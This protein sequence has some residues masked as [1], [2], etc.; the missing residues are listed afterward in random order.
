MGDG[1]AG[2]LPYLQ[3]SPLGLVVV[4]LLRLWTRAVADVRDERRDH[5]RTQ[6]A[7]DAERAHRRRVEDELA[8]VKREVAALRAEVMATRAEVAG[9]RKQLG[10][11]S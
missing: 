9:L 11:V 4:V 1:L 5:E 8:E 10:E 3:Y 6:K 2:L 7:L